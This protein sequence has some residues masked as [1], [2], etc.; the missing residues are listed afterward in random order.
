MAV[1][2]VENDTGSVL[3]ITATDDVTGVVI[4]LTGSTVKLRYKIKTALA[5]EKTMTIDAVPT[6]G[7]AT[8]QFLAGELSPG[9]FRGE[10]EI[11]GAGGDVTTSLT[12]IEFNIKPRKAP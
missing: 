5:V 1:Q 12:D 11:T 6:T 8:Y 4:N 2:F 9:P 10:V 7:K 3:E